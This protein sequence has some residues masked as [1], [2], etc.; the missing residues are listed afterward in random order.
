MEKLI[1]QPDNSFLAALQSVSGSVETLFQAAELFPIPIQI[2]TPDGFTVYV[3]HAVLAM[4][5]IS[6][7]SEIVGRWNLKTDPIVNGRMGYSDCIRRIFEGEIVMVSDVKA[8]IDAFAPWYHTRTTDFNV[9]SMYMD[10]LNFPIL[11][12]QGAITHIVSA[13]LST[14]LY[15]GKAD[16]ARA[17]EYIEQHWLEAF[18]LDAVAGVV[19]LSRYHFA[20]LF[21]K[22]TGMTPYG[23]YQQVKIGRLKQAL[24]DANLS[25][26]DAFSICGLAYSGSMART[27]KKHTGMTPSQYRRI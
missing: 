4:W 3:N 24:H 22:H 13:F 17:K 8:P 1:K 14:R 26:A 11:D 20:R 18:D 25:I 7:R 16:I 21:K 23:Y 15:L 5:N 27:F 19:H 10:I 6:D 12:A 2:F 9:E